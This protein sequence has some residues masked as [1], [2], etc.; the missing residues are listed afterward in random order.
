MERERRVIQNNGR[1]VIVTPFP[2]WLLAH[3]WPVESRATRPF[4]LDAL[5]TA[6]MNGDENRRRIRGQA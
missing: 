4:T 6:W 1:V 3:Y 2:Q 5:I